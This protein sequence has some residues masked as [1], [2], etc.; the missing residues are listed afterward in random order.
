MYLAWPFLI[1]LSVESTSVIR[2]SWT[3]H[4][5]IDGLK[6]A[7]YVNLDH[8]PTR[9]N[10][11]ETQLHNVGLSAQ[12]WRAVD[13]MQVAR[14][15]FDR[16]YVKKQGLSPDILTKPAKEANGTIG[17]FLSHITALEEAAKE[18]ERRGQNDYLLMMEDDVGI[19]DDWEFLLQKAVENAPMDWELLKISGWGSARDGD[20]QKTSTFSLAN[21]NAI[22]QPKTAWDK[23]YAG[24]TSLF[25]KQEQEVKY[26]LMTRPFTEPAHFWWGTLGLGSANFFY[27]GTG[28]Y[29]VRYSALQRVI[30]HLRGQP[31]GDL[32]AM[33]LSNG[34]MRFYEG[35][36]HV[37]DLSSDAFHGPGLHG[38]KA[39]DESQDSSKYSGELPKA[40]VV[41]EGAQQATTTLPAADDS[42]P[43]AVSVLEEG[44]IVKPP[45]KLA[46]A[47]TDSGS[48]RLMRSIQPH[49]LAAAPSTS[50][51]IAST[52]DSM[53]D[54]SPADRIS[55]TYGHPAWLKNCGVIYLDVGS[56]IGVQVRKL[57]EPERYPEAPVLQLFSDIFGAEE[58]RRLPSS[59]TGLCALGIEPNP[60]HRAHLASLQENY[61]KR[62]WNVQFYPF[63]AWKEE[64]KLKFNEATQPETE[65]WAAHLNI[66][67]ASWEADMT[68]EAMKKQQVNVRAIN[69]ADFIKS[70][71]PH[72]VKLMKMDIEGAEYET[73]WRMLQQKVFCQGTVDSVFFEAHPWGDVSNWKD[74]RTYAALRKHISEADCGVGGAATN[75]TDLDDETFG[76]DDVSIGRYW[77]AK[78]R[79]ERTHMM[80]LYGLIA[81]FILWWFVRSGYAASI[82]RN[83]SSKATSVVA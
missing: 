37:F 48:K 65:D 81:A 69:L 33:L 2:R 6:A 30:D 3:R 42:D 26:Y 77:E 16:D 78:H 17:C 75:V 52:R 25:T 27:S 73:V 63:A 23:L 53:I 31:I 36:P 55:L 83:L 54:T 79:S 82:C 32:D 68:Q 1:V 7:Y 10:H 29:L 9:K 35:W 59:S 62:G 22:R 5:A 66:V 51:R 74:N 40:A 45:S 39:F 4:S 60:S 12:R 18:K 67:K 41:L 49:G 34:E 28:G 70:L 64:A 20:L 24:V 80:L 50:E 38:R 57:F 15:D 13:W 19:P 72:S 43:M 14:G 58:D 21:D 46:A 71:P 8:M 44:E 47:N 11:M 56:N 76:L 61:T